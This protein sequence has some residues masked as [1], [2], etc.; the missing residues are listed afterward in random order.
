[1]PDITETV[2][3]LIRHL[4]PAGGL[5]GAAGRPPVVD[6]PAHAATSVGQRR[7]VVRGPRRRR[8]ARMRGNPASKA[9]SPARGSAGSVVPR[10]SSAE[11]SRA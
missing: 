1:M 3:L 9:S 8:S 5:Q 6:A 4:L 2:R 11:K 7:D 10:R